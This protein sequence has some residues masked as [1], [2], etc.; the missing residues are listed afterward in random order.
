MELFGYIDQMPSDTVF[1]Y[2][3]L[4]KGI[5]RKNVEPRQ[6]TPLVRLGLLARVEKES[7]EKFFKKTELW[8]LKKAI[9]CQYLRLVAKDKRYPKK[10]RGV[11]RD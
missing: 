11:G 1:S 2:R 8:D 9:E 3:D 10:K 7:R 4:E 5:N 6:I